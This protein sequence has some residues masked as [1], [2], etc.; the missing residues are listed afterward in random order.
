MFTH[1]SIVAT[2]PASPLRPAS[3]SHPKSQ[4]GRR[5][6]RTF[7]A[8]MHELRSLMTTA[9]MATLLA[10]GAV[11]LAHAAEKP[12]T[13]NAFVQDSFSNAQAEIAM[14]KVALEK[15]SN[16][17]T[18]KL[19]KT[20]IKDNGSAN[21]KL[22]SLASTR[23]L[24]VPTELDKAQLQQLEQLKNSDKKTFDALYSQ[25]LQQMHVASIQLFDQVAKNPRADAELRVF[26]SQRLPA[27]RKQQQMLEKIAGSS[28]KPVQRQAA[29]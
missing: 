11:Q 29:L 25:H 14:S 3:P 4:L 10:L 15:S 2:I 16:A 28:G 5:I 24:T 13:D 1:D 17:S 9:M 8:R 22:R 18:K 20:I 19:A 26:A 27:I 23:K 7:N 12:V 21:E 6:R